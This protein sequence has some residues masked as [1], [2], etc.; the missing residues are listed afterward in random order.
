MAGGSHPLNP[1]KGPGQGAGNS[2]TVPFEDFAKADPDCIVVALC[3]IGIEATIREMPPLTTKPWWPELKAVKSGRVWIVDGNQ[4]FNRPGPRL[5][6]ALEWLVSVLNDAPE[7]CP[8]DFP[9]VKWEES[10]GM[11]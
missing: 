9:V 2:F 1:C 6:D 10:L 8:K 7:A 3:G 11:N 4:M 5:V